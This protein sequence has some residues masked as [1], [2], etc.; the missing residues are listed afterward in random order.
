MA[1]EYF[2]QFPCKVREQVAQ[3]DLLAMLKAQGRYQAIVDVQQKS[4]PEGKNIGDSKIV[5]IQRGPNG[6]EKVEVKLSELAGQAAPLKQL[7]T[8]CENCPAN[9]RQA[10]FG[11][12]GTLHYP[13]SLRAEE[14]LISRLPDDLTSNQGKMLL[15]A[16]KDFN[17]DGAPIDR[18]RSSRSLFQSDKPCQR[19]WGGFLSKKTIINSSQVLQM[20]MHVGHLSPSH[21]KLAAYFVGFVDD[22]FRYTDARQ[23]KDQ[24]NDAPGVIGLKAFL[25]AVGFA[26]AN[27]LPVFIEA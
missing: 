10:E 19:K 9:L 3:E 7:A 14:W 23:T 5:L 15:A 20:L 1:L 13:I 6:D 11:C 22:Q 8:I 21:A 27:N 16:L 18:L 2:I 24:P 12:G 25:R 4:M 26:G 17:F